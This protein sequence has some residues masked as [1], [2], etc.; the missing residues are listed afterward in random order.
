M[1]SAASSTTSSPDQVSPETQANNPTVLPGEGTGIMTLDELKAY[2]ETDEGKRLV[3]WVTTE[4]SRCK[5]ARSRKE[6]MWYY[7]M[8]M[9]FGNQWLEQ[10]GRGLPNGV[11]GKLAPV[12]TPRYVNRKTINRLR[13]FVRAETSKFL[14]TIPIVEAIPASGEDQDL[15]SAN[16]AE[17]VWE[18]YAS[19]RQLRRQYSNSIWWMVITGN[20]F[21]KTWW[22]PTITDRTSGQP[23]D[24][25]YRSVTPFHI[26]VPDLRERELDDQPYFIHAQ[27]KNIEWAKQ[28][29]AAELEGQ[30]ISPSTVTANTLL[31]EAYLNLQESPRSDLDSIVI[32][33]V[34]VRPKQCPLLPNGGWL[35]LVED[36]LVALRNTG[37]PYD[38]GQFPLTKFEHLYNDSFYADSP[39][40][41]LIQLQKEYNEVRTDLA[42]AGKRM[43]RPQIA[44]QKGSIDP[45]KVTNEPG[46][47]LLYNQGFNPP[48]QIQPA[49]IPEYVVSQQDRI[50]Q[51]FEDLSGQHE[52]SRGDAPPGV[53]AGTAISFLQEKDDQ[54]LTPQYQN[55]EDGF[56]RTAIQ[57]LAL[58]QQFVDIPRAIKVIGLDQTFDTVM[59]A[60]ADIAGGTDIR[61]EPGSSIGQTQAAKRATIMDMFSMGII[62][63]P[64]QALQLMEVGGAQRITSMLDAARKKASRENMKMRGVTEEMIAQN[65]AQFKAEILNQMMSATGGAGE[66]P[67]A[68]EEADSVL[69][70][71]A[72]RDPE[73]AQMISSMIPPVV[74]VDDFDIH[75]IHIQEHN[76]FRM[77]QEY[78]N[79]PDW[80]K[81][82]MEKHVQIHEE[83]HAEQLFQQS[84]MMQG[85]PGTMPSEQGAPAPVEQGA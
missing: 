18:S 1:T 33:E 14:S 22:D 3:S 79:W 71:I 8:A 68:P 35:V 65:D 20:G 80:K 85:P 2:R 10:V 82:E 40:V 76:R 32:Y 36:V 53:T 75:A 37:I 9:V 60:S 59:L 39:L 74:Q 38:H 30:S 55:I 48:T 4:F 13:S 26:F 52:V 16:A 70:V 64:N 7:H 31:D 67:I 77:G 24:I 17:Q 62:T 44:A 28:F 83:Q 23:G 19:R 29:Y 57:T 69:Q 21:L 66:P 6:R 63:D 34:W 11:A 56:E 15:A 25:M 45:S 27:V 61:V 51:D 5:T 50:L 41:D 58:F 42:L 72:Q 49:P 12:K 54:Y 73:S 46:L 47:I 81:A 84:Q 78:E 43:G